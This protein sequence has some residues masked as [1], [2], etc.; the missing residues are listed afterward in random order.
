MKFVRSCRVFI[1]PSAL[2]DTDHRLLV[3]DIEFPSTKQALRSRL[4]QSPTEE[5]LKT[6][7]AALQK[8]PELQQELSDRLETELSDICD[9][10]G[11]DELNEKISSAVSIGVDQ[12][13][14]KIHPTKKKEPW[15]DETLLNMLNEAK[16]APRKKFRELRKRIK[17]RRYKLKNEY[18]KELANSINT[19]A[20]ARDVQK[21]FA[22]A[23]KYSILKKGNTQ[24]ISNDKL[25]K[26]FSAHFAERELPTPPE[27]ENPDEYPYLKDTLY[28]ISEDPPSSGEVKQGLK[29]F[30]NNRSWG[31]DNLRQ[32]DLN[33]T[34]VK[35]L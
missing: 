30:K 6:D 9:E 7:F 20:E 8:S 16:N 25:M 11:I 35:L 34:L 2:F 15:E 24:A 19:A 31:N 26:H 3:M 21:E 29:S 28:T 1:G 5:R 14:P 12:T 22:L 32:K 23:R 17:T 33:T 18:Y 4:Y 27:I 10:V 13:C